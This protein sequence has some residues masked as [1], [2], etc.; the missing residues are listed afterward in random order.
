MK[1]WLIA[2]AVALSLAGCSRNPQDQ[3]SPFAAE[4]QEEAP[5]FPTP[6]PEPRATGPVPPSETS[7][8]RLLTTPGEIRAVEGDQVVMQTA[9]NDVVSFQVTPETHILIEG[10]EGIAV[11][12]EAL[13]PGMMIRASWRDRSGQKVAERIDVTGLENPPGSSPYKRGSPGER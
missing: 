1:Y 9:E 8:V 6:T 3:E 7:G 4:K 10:P 5:A 11:G 12:V 13:E 2:G